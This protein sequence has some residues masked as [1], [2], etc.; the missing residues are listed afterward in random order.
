MV[1]IYLAWSDSNVIRNITLLTI[2][3]AHAVLK[4][5]YVNV[6]VEV[7]VNVKV[8]VVNVE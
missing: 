2:S 5:A 1:G 8:K 4:Y 3:L 6:N 7:K